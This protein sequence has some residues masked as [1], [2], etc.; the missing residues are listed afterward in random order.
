MQRVSRLNEPFGQHVTLDATRLE[1]AGTTTEANRITGIAVATL[2]TWPSRGGGRPFL[3]LGRRVRYQGRVLLVSWMGEHE[4]R[5]TEDPGPNHASSKPH[6]A[7]PGAQP[8]DI[9]QLKARALQCQERSR[10]SRAS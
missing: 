10:A 4:C 3:E 5:N 6:I 2:E 1:Q 8:S 7:A 9:E